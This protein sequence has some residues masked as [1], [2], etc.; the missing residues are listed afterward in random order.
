MSL[1]TPQ[2]GAGPERLAA[3]EASQR[4]EHARKTRLVQLRTMAEAGPDAAEHLMSAQ[5]DTIQRVP[6]LRRSGPA[7][8][9]PRHPRRRPPVPRT[10][11][12]QPY[13]ERAASPLPRP[14]PTRS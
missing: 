2:A 8:D 13:E 9:G 12:P 3:H 5:K 14:P 11:R 6:R 1:D 7:A 10:P 4:L